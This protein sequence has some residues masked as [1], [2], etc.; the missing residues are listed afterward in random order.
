M[1]RIGRMPVKVPAG[2]DVAVDGP[3]V[4]VKG[5]KGELRF[6]IHEGIHVEKADGAVV[7]KRTSDQKFYRALHGL[8]RAVI[9]NM[10]TG[11]TQGYQKVLE[12][13]GVGYRAAKQGNKV[14]LTVGF[15]HPVEIEPLPG[16]ELEVPAPTRIVVRGIDKAAVGEM[17]ARIRRVRPA[18]PY[19][20]KGIAYE[21]ERIRRKAGKAGKVAR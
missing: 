7:V 17:A 16:V 12:L 4:R 10:V 9:A 5:P 8:T 1:S 15:S 18:E 14:V 19:L 11:V 2:V 20:G 6:P 3:T 13:R 21:G